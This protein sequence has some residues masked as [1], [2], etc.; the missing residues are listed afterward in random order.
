LIDCNKLSNQD[1]IKFYFDKT[2]LYNPI[3]TNHV[4]YFNTTSVL[5]SCKVLPN[6]LSA[7]YTITSNGLDGEYYQISSFNINPI[8]FEDQKLQFTIKQKDNESFSIKTTSISSVSAYLSIN[9][10]YLQP[11]EINTYLQ[12]DGINTYV[13]IT[14]FYTKFR[15]SRIRRVLFLIINHLKH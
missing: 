11:D 14:N 13:Y 5:L 1:I 8:Q 6:T 15:F 7:N 9:V 4:S 2:N 10:N 3:S 12:P